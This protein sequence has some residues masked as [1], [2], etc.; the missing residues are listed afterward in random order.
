MDPEKYLRSQGWKPGEGLR[1]GSMKRPLLVKHR[2]DN[3]GLGHNPMANEGWWE[4]VFDGH[5]KSLDAF[6][7]SKGV[8][9]AKDEEKLRKAISPL[10]T[11]F[12]PGGVL[13]GT[14]E[15]I[16][17]GDGPK[18]RDASADKKRSNSGKESVKEKK[19]KKKDNKTPKSLTKKDKKEKNV[20]RD[21]KD[22]KKSK[23]K[24]DKKN[25]RTELS[26]KRKLSEG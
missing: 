12:R 13:E 24:K 2:K 4:R 6:S 17:A 25:T 14:I 18:A 3:K 10:Y 22:E 16:P 9:F 21:K 20:A 26:R 23:S 1:P 19:S 7:D 11:M 5:L 15:V 8:T